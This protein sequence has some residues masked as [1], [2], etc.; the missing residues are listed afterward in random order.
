MK[1]VTSVTVPVVSF[2]NLETPYQRNGYRDYFAVV[3][4]KNLPSLADWR[5]IN[6]RD[7]KITGA[8]PRAIQRGFQD[9]AEMFLFMN[10]GLV[11]SVDSVSFD[12]KTSSM[13]LNFSDP[14]LHGLLDGGHTYNIVR[15]AIEGSNGVPRYLK[16]EILEGFGTDDITQIVDARNTSNQVADESLINLRGEFDELKQ[17]LK[18]APYFDKVA[19]KEFEYD[20]Q[21]VPKPIDIRE[22]VAILTAFDRENFSESIHPINTYRS[23][24]AVLKHFKEHLPSYKKIY[25]LAQQL[26][27]LFDQI[28]LKLPELYNK[29]RGQTGGVSGGKFGKLTGVVY[30]DGKL[31]SD[32]YFLGV[33]SK[34]GVPAG[35]VYPILGAFRALLEE[36]DGKYVWGSGLDPVKLLDTDLGLKLADTIGNFA[37]EAQNPSKTGKSPLVWQACFQSV[38]VAYLRAK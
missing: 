1:N 27:E 24:S 6:V 28:Q 26:L 14:N 15:E 18:G 16:V 30:R 8:V 37:L 11:L 23:K 22:V 10:R 35:F 9:Y 21:G 38:E 25:P 2:R 32:L 20:E 12:Q 13:T 31:V 34:Y 17:A 19:F 4:V 36:R 3:D 5:R 7:P 29:A 33:K